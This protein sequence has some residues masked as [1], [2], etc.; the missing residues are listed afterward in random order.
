[1]LGEWRAVEWRRGHGHR[2]AAALH[3]ARARSTSPT[4]SPPSASGRRSSSAT[5][6]RTSSIG[7]GE[8]A[9]SRI[10]QRARVDVDEAGTRAAATTAVMARAV[11]LPTNP[12][13]LT[14][15]RPFTW[16]VEH[17]PTGTLL[18]VGRVLQPTER[19]D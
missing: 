4:R 11:S 7:P 12:F 8:K 2:R 18:F 5:T 13:H 3:H 10:L 19:S 16:A 15:D 1:M 6:S 14:F 9:L 17:A